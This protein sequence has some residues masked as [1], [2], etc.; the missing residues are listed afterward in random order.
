MINKSTHQKTLLLSAYYNYYGPTHYYP[1]QSQGGPGEG[2][3]ETFITAA[4]ALNE[5]FYTVREPVNAIGRM[6]P[7]GLEGSAMIQHDPHQDYA[8]TRKGIYRILDPAAA[9]RPD[10]LFIHAH[11]P[12]LNPE[13]IFSDKNEINPTE[14]NGKPSKGWL[15]PEDIV[16][17]LGKDL[18]KQVW[19]EMR[20]VACECEKC[21]VDW[22]GK[23]GICRRV[24]Q[25]V[26]DVFPE[27]VLPNYW[28]R[29]LFLNQLR[30][31]QKICTD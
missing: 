21:F 1:L 20:W 7:H 13:T 11:Y 8:I 4:A 24:N 22:Q 2:D 10:V 31:T 26:R 23:S 25:Y 18:E 14:F 16:A 17:T 29:V 28:K 12:K 5:S 30:Q 27:N 3:K 9:P 6:T 15:F 19:K